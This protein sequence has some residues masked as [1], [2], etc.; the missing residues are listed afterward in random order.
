MNDKQKRAMQYNIEI[1]GYR[2]DKFL[3]KECS[4]SWNGYNANLLREMQRHSNE[5]V[6]L[7]EK[8][9]IND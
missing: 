7:A 2:I 1:Q 5:L 8:L 3:Q 6:K 9:K 4:K